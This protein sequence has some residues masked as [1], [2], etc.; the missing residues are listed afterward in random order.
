MEIE[1]SRRL[2]MT[3][4]HL[5]SAYDELAMAVCDS[6]DEACKYI[7]EAHRYVAKLLANG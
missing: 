6:K 5:E 2:V 7:E 1:K 3:L 4:M